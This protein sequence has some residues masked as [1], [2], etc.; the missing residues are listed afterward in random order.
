MCV[1]T[2]IAELTPYAGCAFVPTMGALH[3][4]HMALIERAVQSGASPVVV[5][6]FVNPTQFGPG[7][8]YKSY[9][10]E[11]D[12]DVQ[13]A[14]RAGADFIFAPSAE[15]MYPESQDVVVPALPTVATEPGLED[16]HRPDHFAG[17]CL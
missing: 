6:V 9:P 16:A 11:L 13:A 15:T 5:S 10:R 12:S 8:D 17:V 4:G 7:E 2:D 3:P 1:L 14:R